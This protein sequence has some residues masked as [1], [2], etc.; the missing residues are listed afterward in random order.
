MWKF[1]VKNHKEWKVYTWQRTSLP[2]DHRQA[3]QISPLP[4]DVCGMLWSR[5]RSNLLLELPRRYFNASHF[6]LVHSMGAP[7]ITKHQVNTLYKYNI[8]TCTCIT[9]NWILLLQLLS[10]IARARIPL[11]TAVICKAPPQTC[12][13]PSDN[14]P[15]FRKLSKL[16]EIH[17]SSSRCPFIS[18]QIYPSPTVLQILLFQI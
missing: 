7:G 9:L 16:S 10:A 14:T 2:P 1:S 8:V 17:P 15:T 12:K 11:T 18:T 4:D 5:S 6:S 3:S 13:L